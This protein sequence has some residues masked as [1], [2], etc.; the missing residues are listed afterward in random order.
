MV[1]ITGIWVSPIVLMTSMRLI[2]DSIVARHVSETAT[3][4]QCEGR[5]SR[6]RPGLKKSLWTEEEDERLRQACEVYGKSWADVAMMLHGRSNQQ[7]SERWSEL[8]LGSGNPAPESGWR[9]NPPW[10][11]EEEKRLWNAAQDSKSVDWTQIATQL[12]TDRAAK[13]VSHTN[14]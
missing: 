12:G 7:C 10:T 11:R 6:I 1:M 3:P 8:L 4:V 5:Y 2:V 9:Y 13:A 14:H